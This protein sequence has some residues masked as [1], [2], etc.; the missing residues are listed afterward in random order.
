MIARSILPLF[1]N[2]RSK[3]TVLAIAAVFAAFTGAEAYGLELAPVVPGAPHAWEGGIQVGPYSTANLANGNVLSVMPIIGWDGLGPDISFNLYHNSADD[4]WRLSYMAELCQIDSTTVTLTQDDGREVGFNFVAGDWVPEAGYHYVL[5]ADGAGGWVLTTTDQ[6]KLYFAADVSSCAPLSKIADSAGNELQISWPT[7]S[8]MVV[9]DAAMR[10]LTVFFTGGVPT[11]IGDTILGSS[12]SW[13]LSWDSYPSQLGSVSYPD[14]TKIDIKYD[15]AGGVDF[16]ISDKYKTVNGGTPEVWTM[17]VLDGN[18]RLTDVLTR[19][20]FVGTP[21]F[22]YTQGF[23]YN[24]LGSVIAVT[25]YTDR[26]GETHRFNYLPNYTLKNYSSPLTGKYPLISYLFTFDSERNLTEFSEWGN[27]WSLAYD[28]NGNILSVDDPLGNRREMAYDGLNNV[29]SYRE[30]PDYAGNPGDFGEWVYA[31]TDPTDPTNLTRITQPAVAVDGGAA[32][33]GEILLT[34]HPAGTANGLLDMVTDPN[35]VETRF[36]YDFYGQLASELEGGGNPGDWRVKLTYEMDAASRLLR[37][38]RV[39]STASPAA[40]SPQGP[41]GPT[42]PPVTW[43]YTPMNMLS[44]QSEV[45]PPLKACGGD[46]TTASGGGT[47]AGP[48]CPSYGSMSGSIVAPNASNPPI[49]YDGM[50]RMTYFAQDVEW[51]LP[52]ESY[53]VENFVGYDELGRMTGR[54]T[55]SGEQTSHIEGAG[56]VQTVVGYDY[57]QFESG[58]IITR[59]TSDGAQAQYVFDAAGRIASVVV[60]EEATPSNV[61]SSAEYSYVP[62]RNLVRDIEYGNENKVQYGYDAAGRVTSITHAANSAP[63]QV[64]VEMEWE[65]FLDFSYEYDGRGLITKITELDAS[66]GVG[67]DTFEVTYTYDD[68]HRLTRERRV[69]VTGSPLVVYDLAYTYDL[70]G[71]RKRKIN[72]NYRFAEGA[73]GTIEAIGTMTTTY[74]YDTDAGSTAPH[75]ANRLMLE[76]AHGDPDLDDF[77]PGTF[78][79]DYKKTYYEYALDGDAVGN[80]VRIIRKERPELFG[81]GDYTVHSY[82]FFYNRAGELWHVATQWWQEDFREEL[83]PVYAPQLVHVREFRGSGQSRHMM[84]DRTIVGANPGGPGLPDYDSAVWTETWGDGPVDY[85]VEMDGTAATKN[86]V[87]SYNPGVSD[88]DWT[89]SEATYYHGDQI[90]STQAMTDDSGAVIMRPVYTAFGER[91]QAD[92]RVGSPMLHTQNQPPDLGTRF[93]YAGGYGYESM[94]DLD[95]GAPSNVN[96]QPIPFPYMHLGYR[97]YDPSSGRFLQRDPIGIRGGLNTYAYVNSTPTRSTDPT[98]LLDGNGG[99]DTMNGFGPNAYRPTPLPTKPKPKP[100]PLTPEQELERIKKDIFLLGGVCGLYSWIFTP[101]YGAGFAA[102]GII[103]T[104]WYYDEPLNPL[105][106]GSYEN[107]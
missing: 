101:A 98:G 25:R 64:V 22:E 107:Y 78:D 35:G 88:Y 37:G 86:Y 20:V 15:Q 33:S 14:D 50:D 23:E 85:T 57:S 29:T 60:V 83:N 24:V 105:F 8:Q 93:G 49:K 17:F 77:F 43:A 71:N 2:S 59:S 91:V 82:C 73:G 67:A 7:A 5:E 39:G 90:A 31:Y 28:G 30:W 36:D 80:V 51:S 94:A 84:R 46:C 27:D 44:G 21:A 52:Y 54:T 65:P 95:W 10:A 12:R 62:G 103:D 11:S 45:C 70:G 53:S 92:G 9:T 104:L 4:T 96:L 66:G 34:Y 56:L 81:G 32:A 76:V 63:M 100:K 16:A 19:D 68:L 58:N 61:Y 38:E 99:G 40:P 47:A 13:G 41:E 26:R 75:K 18:N 69:D 6:W 79:Y 42:P 97:W 106:G 102:A 74:F 48:A 3:S 89:S 72:R 1:E 87:R 55:V